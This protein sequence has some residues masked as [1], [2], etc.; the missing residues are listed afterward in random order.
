M[1]E[2]RWNHL[3]DIKKPTFSSRQNAETVTGKQE[4]ITFERNIRTTLIVIICS[5]ICDDEK[6][7]S[8]ENQLTCN[9]LVKPY[10]EN[11]K[12]LLSLCMWLIFSSP[13]TLLIEWGEK[14]WLSLIF[15]KRIQE[16]R[17]RSY[18][19][20]I[21][22]I[23]DSHKKSLLGN[24]LNTRFQLYNFFPLLSLTDCF[25]FRWD[26]LEDYLFS[27]LVALY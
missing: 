9:S 23:I 5:M 13:T 8:V 20:I 12:C 6:K 21:K 24:D 18:T 27:S 10:Q 14:C 4:G 16:R 26:L 19:L 25:F 3:S 11:L 1:T 17:W 2:T 22:S 7:Q 15:K